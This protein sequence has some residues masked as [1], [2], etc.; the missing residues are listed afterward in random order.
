MKQLFAYIL[1]AFTILCI[2]CEE[3]DDI[4]F[5]E[6]GG[7]APTILTGSESITLNKDLEGT[8]ALTLVWEK[9]EID[10]PTPITYTVELAAAGTEFATPFNAASTTETFVTWTV[11]EFNAAVIQA[12]LEPGIEGAVEARVISAIGSTGSI[13]QFSDAITYF[14]T[15][16][17]NKAPELFLVGAFQAYYG[18]NAWT[19]TEAFQMNY[20]GDGSTQIFEGYIK[21][22]ADD[23]FK[24]ISAAADW[25]TLDGNYGTI[26]GAQDGNITNDGGS[27]D[28]KPG[29]AGLYYVQVDIDNLAYQIIRMDWG[30]I[31]AATPL[32]WDGET[33]MTYDFDANQYTITTTLVDGEMKLRSKN[34]SNAIFGA[35]EDWK[36]NVGDSGDE[37]VAADTGDGNFAVSAGNYTISLGIGIDGKATTGITQN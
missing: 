31:G 16:Y 11:E 32:G 37:A 7:T 17:T 27:S 13:A 36:F 2:G 34:T 28:V 1:L 14:A 26:D 8:K 18:R 30:I 6:N 4:Q 24:F 22:G 21:L 20:I 3:S 25:G 19:P 5:T 23:G 9:A 29:V 12:G 10:S 15:P 35:D 33:A